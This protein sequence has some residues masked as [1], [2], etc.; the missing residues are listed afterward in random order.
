MIWYDLA[1]CHNL[2]TGHVQETSMTDEYHASHIANA[3]GTTPKVALVDSGV[4][5]VDKSTIHS[6]AQTDPVYGLQPL[7]SIT[8][9][10]V[11]FDVGRES[12]RIP[13]GDVGAFRAPVS[14]TPTLG[15]FATQSGLAHVP[16]LSRSKALVP[17]KTLKLPV[18][19]V[20]L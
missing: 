13:D 14:F 9:P 5:T 1:F 16:V 8:S 4:Q 15:S 17:S 2:R 11:G 20:S 7:P 10:F 18:L 6:Q 12:R 3:A 19:S